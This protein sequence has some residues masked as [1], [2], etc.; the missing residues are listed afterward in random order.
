MGEDV[1]AIVRNGKVIGTREH[2]VCRFSAIPY[3]QAPVDDLRW[4]A[5]VAA[6]WTGCLDATRPG[7]VAPQ[8]PSRLRGAMGD[9]DAAQS[10]D[11]LHLTVWTPA[12]DGGRRPVVVWLHGGAWQSGGAALEW[13]SGAQLAVQGDIVMVSPNYRLAALG[14]LFVPGMVANV[15]LL[16]QEAAI[17]WVVEHIESF[18]GDPRKITV[19]GQS[20]GAASIACLL[21]RRPRFNRA[22]M[23]SASL[24]RGF[25]SVEQAH[26]LGR[27]LLQAAGARDLD[28]ARTLPWEA[29]LRA[30]QAPEVV[31]A[32]IAEGDHRSLFA[33]VSDG[34]VLP[35]DMQSEL[36]AAAGR[37]DVLI[38]YTGD[39]M[40]AF[41]DAPMDE[42]GRRVGDEIFGAPSRQWAQDAAAQGRGA[43][44]FKFDHAPSDAFGACHCIELPF[45]FGTL[46]RFRDAPM[47]H[48]LRPQDAQRLMREIQA[49][50][51]AF[52][53]GG[54]PGWDA[55]PRIRAFD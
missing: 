47:L 27:I 21:A 1:Q 42:A 40:K 48:G 38:G 37:A 31:E 46:D 14:W 4:R 24:G 23:Q 49:A 8:L 53:R 2:G 13:Y 16:D 20:A 17:D 39:E 30:Q 55:S 11:C 34:E 6:Q 45:V 5:P 32:L 43:W 15:G 44:V 12:A 35:Q 10:E 18:G 22:I 41:P 25:R 36:Q 7:P 19:M 54:S 50:W 52:I 28:E 33:L 26:R 51:I 3:A 29:L 9:F